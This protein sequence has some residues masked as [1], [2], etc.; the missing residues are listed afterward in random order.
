MQNWA[1]AK[2]CLN[3]IMLKNDILLRSRL[4]T[5]ETFTKKI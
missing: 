2:T 4:Q 1:D 3:T 5:Y